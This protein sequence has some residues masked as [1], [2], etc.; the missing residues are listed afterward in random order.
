MLRILQIQIL[1]IWSLALSEGQML[2]Y[3]GWWVYQPQ[4][5]KGDEWAFCFKMPF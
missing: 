3:K 1:D 2:F 4:T 5:E